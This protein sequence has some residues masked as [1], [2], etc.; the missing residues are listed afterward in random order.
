MKK[1]LY[2]VVEKETLEFDGQEECTGNKTLWLYEMIDNHPNEI[3][4]IDGT[5]DE[6][7]EVLIYDYLDDNSNGD[8]KFILHQL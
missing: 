7:S 2:Y 1:H 6:G 5:N 3:A 8:E 4:A